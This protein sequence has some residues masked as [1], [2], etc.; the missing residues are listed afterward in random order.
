MHTSR[1]DCSNVNCKADAEAMQGYPLIVGLAA[2]LCSRS[3]YTGW[4]MN[5]FDRGLNPVP[6]LSTGSTVPKSSNSTFPQQDIPGQKGRMTRFNAV[7]FLI[8]VSCPSCRSC[9]CRRKKCRIWSI[10]FSLLAICFYDH[11]CQKFTLVPQPV[12]WIRKEQI[13]SGVHRNKCSREFL[14]FRVLIGRAGDVR[15]Q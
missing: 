5:Q 9:L 8:H 2:T 10:L 14:S 7:A 6:V 15:P 12:C 13:S 11:R 3:C 4:F 1:R